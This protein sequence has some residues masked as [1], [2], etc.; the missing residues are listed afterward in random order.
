MLLL[1]H[2]YVFEKRVTRSKYGLHGNHGSDKYHICRHRRL[3]ASSVHFFDAYIAFDERDCH[4]FLQRKILHNLRSRH[5][6]SFAH[7][8]PLQYSNN[9]ILYCPINF[10]RVLFRD[11]DQISGQHDLGIDNDRDNSN[12]MHARNH[13]SHRPAFRH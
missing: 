7:S 8:N 13:P 2:V 3:R 6:R 4:N 10:D 12:Y 5:D 9:N 11:D 1:K